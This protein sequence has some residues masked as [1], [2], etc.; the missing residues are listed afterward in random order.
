[1]KTDKI[2]KDLNDALF[3]SEPQRV[4]Q[5]GDYVEISYES[6]ALNSTLMDRLNPIIQKNHLS[7]DILPIGDK[8]QITF[9][10][11]V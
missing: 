7:Y 5:L 8:V 2:V 9:M 11:W 1:M 3:A 6:V 4:M 10:K